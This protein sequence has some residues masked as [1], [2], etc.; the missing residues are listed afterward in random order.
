M[1]KFICD[2]TGEKADPS[3]YGTPPTGWLCVMT[4]GVGPTKHFC[5][6]DAL[7]EYYAEKNG[8]R[9]IVDDSHEE[10]AADAVVNR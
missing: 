5:S 9:V 8:K 10:R 1:N 3:P 4:L 2:Q 6:E 7:L